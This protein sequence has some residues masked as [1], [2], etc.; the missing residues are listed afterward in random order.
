MKRLALLA[1]LLVCAVS[2]HAQMPGELPPLGPQ[3]GHMPH[4]ASA[5]PL[6]ITSAQCPTIVTGQPYQCQFTATGG[7][8]PYHWSIAGGVAPPGLSLSDSGML[9]G[10]VYTCSDNHPLNCFI[11]P[12]QSI[13][14]ILAGGA[15]VTIPVETPKKA[16]KHAAK[17]K[18]A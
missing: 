18:S 13:Q 9:S 16:K 17:P 15:S 14:M 2:L 12:P 11:I 3:V 6:Q 10:T 1:L 7:T 8:P 5:L 4:D